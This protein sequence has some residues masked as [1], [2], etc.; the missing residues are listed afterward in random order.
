M[1]YFFLF[2]LC[3][4]SIIFSSCK[5]NNQEPSGYII[6]QI[7]GIQYDFNYIFQGPEYGGI[8][9]YSIT[10]S[11]EKSLNPTNLFTIQFLRKNQ[12]ASVP[13]TLTN[14]YNGFGMQISY[15]NNIGG[16]SANDYS[17]NDFSTNNWSQSVSNTNFKV[18]ITDVSENM[19]MG[20]FEGRIR[21]YNNDGTFRQKNISNGSFFIPFSN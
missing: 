14:N 16:N 20:T 1:R 9:D 10:F 13:Y 17:V 8:F 2:L 18:I 21:D 15:K 3:I 19:I 6:A 4:N 5:K 7:D 12:L 11:K